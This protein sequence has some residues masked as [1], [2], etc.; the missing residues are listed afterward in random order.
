MIG[1]NH[2]INFSIQPKIP[3]KSKNCVNKEEP[4][5]ICKWIRAD[6]TRCILK[7]ILNKNYCK[8][9]KKFENI[10]TP[11][12]IFDLQR[13][14]RCKKPVK[15]L[16][17]NQKKCENCLSKQKKDKLVLRKKR[18]ENKKKCSWINQKGNPCPWNTNLTT[19]YCKRHSK[20]HGIFEPSDIPNLKKCSGCKNL[21]KSESAEKICLKC[22]TRNKQIT[23][24]KMK[25]NIKYCSAITICNKPCSYK[26]LKNDNYCKKHQRYKKHKLLID[27][28]KRICSN[29]IRGCFNELLTSDMS[30]CN[31]CKEATNNTKLTT[32]LTIY[33]EKYTTYKSEAV[34]RNIIWDLTKEQT[35]KLF[36]EKCEYCAINDGLNGIDRIDSTKPY[37]TNNSITCCAI[38]NKMKLTHTK[39]QF[40]LIV[41][42][43]CEHLSLFAKNYSHP[44]IYTLFEK[45]KT[46]KTYNT[47][48]TNCKNKKNIKMELTE[49]QFYNILQYPCHYCGH[50]SKDGSNGIDRIDP[51]LYYSI[52]NVVPCCKTCNFIKGSQTLFHF[53]E[54]LTNIYKYSI[55]H[56]IPD[57]INN[58]KTKMISILS[59]N[60]IK[61]TKY[62]SIKLQHPIKFYNN[63]VFTGN[64]ID[65]K[66]MKIKLIFTNS[67]HPQ[68]DIWQYYRR[69]ISSFKPKKGSCLLGKRT[70]IL[71][72]DENSG[73]YLGII[74]ISSDIKFLGQRDKYIGWNKHHQFTLKKLDKLVNIT[75]CVSTQPFGYNFNGGKLL[76]SLAFSKEV[77]QFWYDTYNTYIQGISTMS[78]YGKSIQYDRLQCIKYLGLTK[79]MSVK[80]I[81][82]EAVKYA[83]EYLYSVGL[84]DKSY[85]KNNLW[86]FKKCLGKLNIPIEDVLKSIKKGVYFG[87]TTPQSKIYLTSET[88]NNEPNPIPYAKTT[89]EIY[90]W[91]VNRWANQR[92]THLK[93]N[94]KIQ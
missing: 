45:A 33:E 24:K 48:T 1:D 23:Q 9:H 62:P 50:F 81:S 85:E 20:Y 28:G 39:R 83:K 3:K 54:K 12:D 38:C 90:N 47:Y 76:T 36:K 65:V 17:V 43:I 44:Y 73:K 31:I 72:Q 11:D 67:K 16:Q 58:P 42:C 80:D 52:E 26:A 41:K 4:I 64:L 15:N 66:N 6:S 18:T 89:N 63:A 69:T 32:S 21:F 10:Y 37:N 22:K 19:N 60:N 68:F 70:Y 91:W 86:L 55:L 46:K 87:Y 13:C 57:Y 34:R 51:Q 35:I 53:K 94:N 59:K 93:K 82:P 77:L 56:E 14:S 49:Q 40:I 75:T 2:V 84:Y 71:V 79:G 78:L 88:I 7:T 30:K 25:K 29:W 5:E 92:Y 61:I 27:S 8:L 74:S